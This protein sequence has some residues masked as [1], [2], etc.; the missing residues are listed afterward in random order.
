MVPAGTKGK[1][2]SSVNHTTKTIHHHQ[3]EACNF[4]KSTTPPWCF[5]RFLNCTNGTKSRKALQI[6]YLGNITR[7]FLFEEPQ[8]KETE[9]TASMIHFVLCRI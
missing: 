3:A 4:T 5:L 1:R 7:S 8:P 2:F 6:K 9:Y